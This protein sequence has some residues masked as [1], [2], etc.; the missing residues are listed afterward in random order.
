MSWPPRQ[1]VPDRA[2]R[3]LFSAALLKPGST[4][5][6]GISQKVMSAAAARFALFRRAN[7]MKSL[8]SNEPDNP[9]VKSHA[10]IWHFL[11]N[12]YWQILDFLWVCRLS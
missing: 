1:G 8:L 7:L 4:E 5:Y 9:F 3:K 10:F 6:V 12:K 11:I 2:E